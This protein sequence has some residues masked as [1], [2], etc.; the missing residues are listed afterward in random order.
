MSAPTSARV[1]TAVNNI[2][3]VEVAGSLSQWQTHFFSVNIQ[4]PGVK[5]IVFRLKDTTDNR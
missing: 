3:Y 2:I 5:K 1:L 4:T